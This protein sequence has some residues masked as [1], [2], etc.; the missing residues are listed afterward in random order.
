MLVRYQLLKVLCM[1]CDVVGLLKL[2]VMRMG[3]KLHEWQRIDQLV[4]LFLLLH[5]KDIFSF[6]NAHVNDV[7]CVFMNLIDSIFLIWIYHIAFM[8]FFVFC[9]P[10]QLSIKR[11][12]LDWERRKQRREPRRSEHITSRFLSLYLFILR[13]RSDIFLFVVLSEPPH[14]GKA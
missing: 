2:D 8:F 6:P 9:L 5:N 13:K 4:V 11:V 7:I 14:L 3:L 1:Y 10:W 12:K